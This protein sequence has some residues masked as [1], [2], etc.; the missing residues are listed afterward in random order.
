MISSLQRN[1]KGVSEIIGYVLLIVIA[2]ALSVFVYAY[3][4]LYVPKPSPEC[5]DAI[6][7]TIQNSSCTCIIGGNPPCHLDLTLKN[8]GL[9]KVHAAYV[10]ADEPSK[11]IK[12]EISNETSL[13]L[14]SLGEPALLPGST[15]T[16]IYPM[17]DKTGSFTAQPGGNYTLEVQ[18]AVYDE[19]SRLIACNNAIITQ[20]LECRA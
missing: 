13:F 10:R 6:H 7:L 19:K 4:K 11:K 9:F 2:L 1:K 20:S 8:R 18:P 12:Q 5:Q 17:K 3:L 16:K 14:A 15:I